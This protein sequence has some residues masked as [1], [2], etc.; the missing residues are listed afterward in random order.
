MKSGYKFILASI[1]LFSCFAFISFRKTQSTE[2][3]KISSPTI[4]VS[5]SLPRRFIQLAAG[6]NFSLA[7]RSDGTV[8]SWG[9]NTNGQLGCG[10][11]K[12]SLLP[13]QVQSLNGIISISA[14]NRHALALKSDGTVWAWGDNTFGQIGDGTKTTVRIPVQVKSLT[15]VKA[16]AAGGDNYEVSYQSPYSQS[17][18]STQT[19]S[20]Y[21]QTS[22]IS[23]ALKKDGTV[24]T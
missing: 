20:Y 16:I 19:T 17:A 22:G 24:W 2:S 11:I 15:D 4:S 14:G 5:D 21:S 6:G 3:N 10:A 18:G 7:L 13:V 12:E 23:V 8:W 9:S 1:L